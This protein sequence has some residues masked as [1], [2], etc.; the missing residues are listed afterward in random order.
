MHELREYEEEVEKLQVCWLSVS[1]SVSVS[2]SDRVCMCVYND[3]LYR[4]G[5]EA[6]GV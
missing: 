4:K 5:G 6:A 3:L 2:V 1:V